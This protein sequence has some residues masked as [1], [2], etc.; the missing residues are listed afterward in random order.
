MMDTQDQSSAANL[1]PLRQ[2][3]REGLE[4]GEQT[5]WNAEELKQEGRQKRAASAP[6]ADLF[7]KE[8]D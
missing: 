2:A 7:A 3:I 1:E 5:T 4:S 8:N 6:N